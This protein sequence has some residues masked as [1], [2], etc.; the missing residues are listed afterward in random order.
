M[1][2][3]QFIF[4]HGLSGWGSYDEH[5]AKNPYWGMRNGDLMK[6]LSDKGYPSYAASVDSHGSAWDRACE[7]YAQL[8]GTRTDY[9]KTHCEKNRHERFGP[10][11]T[12]RPLIQTM[13]GEHP[14]VLTGHSFGG[15]TVRLFAHLMANGCQQE[16]EATDPE[17]LS[18][19]FKGGHADMIFGILTLASPH[20][21]T[22]AYDLFEDPSFDVDSVKVPLLSR[23]FAKLITKRNA[24]VPDGRAAEDYASYDMH[25]D[26]ADKINQMI[27]V[28]PDTYYFS[29][30]CSFT[31]KKGNV[32]YPEVLKMEPFFV[33]TSTQMG[34]YTGT[35]KG[36]MVI[37]ETWQENDGLVNTISAKAPSHAPSR[38][39]D[40]GRI[41][42]GIW[43]IMPVWHG[44][45]MSLQGGLMKKHE[46]AFFYLEMVQRFTS[47]LK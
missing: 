33:K 45:H 38:P 2:Q 14:L 17:D 27:A 18:P 9:G 36:G 20:N 4:V 34:A 8:A 40:P 31:K 42:P 35:T 15:V 28:L 7:L 46:V 47:L 39:F 22:T 6:L 10:D 1:K 23:Q 37:D 13:D 19:F 12:G 41:E 24:I 29:V 32:Q 16:Q 21:G 5:Y 43:N 44:D 11:F 26:V 25:I 3:L 30:P